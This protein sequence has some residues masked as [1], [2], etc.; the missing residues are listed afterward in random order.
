MF[1]DEIHGQLG[2]LISTA[3]NAGVN[4]ALDLEFVHLLFKHLAKLGV[5][6]ADALSTTVFVLEPAAGKRFIENMPKTECLILSA[7][8]QKIAS[9][10]WPSA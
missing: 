6:D 9:R 8:E 4:L 1:F 7:T 5:M 2:P 3:A 10:G